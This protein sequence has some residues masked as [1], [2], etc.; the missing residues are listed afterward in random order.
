MNKETFIKAHSNFPLNSRLW[1]YPSDRVLTEKE[2]A[3]IN[4]SLVQFTQQWAA[5]GKQLEASS[6]VLYDT[7]LVLIVNENVEPAS[8][9]SI[10]SSVKIIKEIGTKLN[11]DF[12]NRNNIIFLKNN[13][14]EFTNLS[15]LTQLNDEIVFNSSVAN[16]QDFQNKFELPFKESALAKVNIDNSFTFSL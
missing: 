13:E 3:F 7:F 15:N 4:E 2:Q 1:V 12:F 8:G 6:A 10:D 16:F 9:C 11:V 5:H 14:I